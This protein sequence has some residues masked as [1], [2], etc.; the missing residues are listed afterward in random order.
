MKLAYE[1]E[2]YILQDNRKQN[3]LQGW[4]TGENDVKKK[5]FINEKKVQ[6]Y[7][8]SFNKWGIIE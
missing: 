5:V 2:H 4:D 3:P 8:F 1:L 6:I 7:V